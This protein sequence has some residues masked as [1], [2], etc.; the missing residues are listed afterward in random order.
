L[1]KGDREENKKLKMMLESTQR[2]FDRLDAATRDEGEED[3]A[4][5]SDPQPSHPPGSPH[6]HL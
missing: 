1:L 2:D 3:V 6:Y 4:T 5:T